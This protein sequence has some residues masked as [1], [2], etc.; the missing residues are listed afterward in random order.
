MQK[1]MEK[2]P[3]PAQTKPNDLEGPP[4]EPEKEETTFRY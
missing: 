1:M 2:K 3:M 4:P